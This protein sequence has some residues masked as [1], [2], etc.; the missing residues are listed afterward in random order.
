MAQQLLGTILCITLSTGSQQQFLVNIIVPD[1]P[2]KLRLLAALVSTASL[3]WLC[4]L[5]LYFVLEA[6]RNVFQ[7][8]IIVLA[9]KTADL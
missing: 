8:W 7:A 4:G 2:R 6:C 1:I 5:L 3:Q 9:A